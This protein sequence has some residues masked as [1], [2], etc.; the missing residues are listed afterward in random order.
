MQYIVKLKCFSRS[1]VVDRK[2][3][4][5]K[6]KAVVEKKTVI[7]IKTSIEGSPENT[8]V[9]YDKHISIKAND[10]QIF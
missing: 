8:V 1:L 6:G 7:T 5:K 4:T 3:K 10:K 2:N 9:N